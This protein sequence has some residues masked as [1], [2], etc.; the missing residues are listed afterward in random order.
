MTWSNWPYSDV[1]EVSEIIDGLCFRKKNLENN[2]NK[3]KENK[4]SMYLVKLHFI[5]NPNRSYSYLASIPLTVG[6]EYTILVDNKTNYDNA[7][8]VIEQCECYHNQK[9][10]FKLRTITKATSYSKRPSSGIKKVIFNEEKRITIVLWEDGMKTKVVC[11]PNDTFDRE[12]AIA[13]CYM[14][15]AFN[16]RGC[17]N[18]TLKEWC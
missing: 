1:N 8:V 9:F 17:F 6:N 14:K 16:N 7:H 13:L 4:Q 10:K 18:E 12:K 11:S 3:N 15:R 5:S 2:I